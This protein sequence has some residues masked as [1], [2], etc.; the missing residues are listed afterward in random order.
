MFQQ[1]NKFGVSGVQRLV[2]KRVDYVDMNDRKMADE[3]V[4]QMR[5]LASRYTVRLAWTFI[6]RTDLYLILEYCSGGD[7]RKVITNIQQLPEEER[8]DRVWELFTHITLALDFMHSHGVVHRD[9]KPENIFVQEDGSA[10]LGDFGLAKQVVED[11]FAAV[12]GTKRY[13]APEVWMT[14]KMTFE[15]DIYAL[16]VV[17]YELI[18][19]QHPFSAPT[20]K[21]MIG[22]A[23]KGEIELMPQYINEELKDLLLKMLSPDILKRP[24]TQDIMMN[25][26]IKTTIQIYDQRLKLREQ[27]QIHEQQSLIL[28]PIQPVTLEQLKSV[29]ADVD[30]MLLNLQLQDP[31]VSLLMQN[32]P[33]K[34]QKEIEKPTEKEF[35]ILSKALHLTRSALNVDTSLITEEIKNISKQIIWRVIAVAEKIIKDE[36]EVRLTIR[37]RLFVE[38]IDLVHRISADNDSELIRLIER[39]CEIGTPEQTQLMYK[40]NTIQALIQ[41]LVNNDKKSPSKTLSQSSSSGQL[42]SY[43]LTYLQQY[44]LLP[45]PYQADLEQQGVI[46]RIIETLL[47]NTETSAEV[48]NGV[49]EFLDTLYVEGAKL[50][51][52]LRLEILTQLL[53]QMNSNQ[54]IIDKLYSIKALSWIAV[55]KENHEAI[56]EAGFLDAIL[57]IFKNVSEG[58]EVDFNLVNFSFEIIKFMF[59]YELFMK[60]IE[61]LK[62]DQIDYDEIGYLAECQA[63]HDPLIANNITEILYYDIW[64]TYPSLVATR[65][66]L[67]FG[68]IKTKKIVAQTFKEKVYKIAYD[69]FLNYIANRGKWSKKE[70]EKVQKEAQEIDALI[71]MILEGAKV[72]FN[73]YIK[74]SKEYVGFTTSFF[75]SIESVTNSDDIEADLRIR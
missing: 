2:V 74:S 38:L 19:G 22:K 34:I 23:Q 64:G 41:K 27:E 11:G 46:R 15:S 37:Q 5:R 35:D 31:F 16:G 10:L 67:R 73:K 7:L 4:A 30:N 54:N 61:Q 45:H 14:G 13:F 51:E 75:G 40:M 17:I 32:N 59:I 21:E 58:I 72:S 24:T 12:A 28:P 63:N 25:T 47:I 49:C 1:A 50:P 18:T 52:D 69:T 70:T 43:S 42:Q 71:E 36:N 56:V 29:N 3:E 20:E 6:D 62:N 60:L 53:Q 33:L 48:R 65:Q 57:D 55:N 8:L 66:L 9:I 68:T 39:I 26:T 44:A